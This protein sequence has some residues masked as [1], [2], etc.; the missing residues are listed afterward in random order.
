MI[1]HAVI[2]IVD[3]FA[4]AKT[5]GLLRDTQITGIDEADEFRRFVVEPRI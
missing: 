3:D 5:A 4:V 1:H 2:D